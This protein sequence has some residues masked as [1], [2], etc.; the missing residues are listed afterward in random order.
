MSLAGVVSSEKSGRL[1]H[2]NRIGNC[3]FKPNFFSEGHHTMPAKNTPY[4][5]ESKIDMAQLREAT[6]KVFAYDTTVSEKESVDSPT[7]KHRKRIRKKGESSACS[8]TG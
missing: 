6:R 1:K 4:E 8:E 5:T 3:H 7:V 2:K